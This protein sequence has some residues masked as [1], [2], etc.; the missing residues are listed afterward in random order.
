M[1]DESAEVSTNIKVD[2]MEEED[3]E[4]QSKLAD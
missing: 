3:H 1:G 2:E 4:I